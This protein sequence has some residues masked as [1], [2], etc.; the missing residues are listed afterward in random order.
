LSCSGEFGVALPWELLCADDLAVIAETEEEL[1]GRLNV[2]K[3]NVESGGVVVGVGKTRVVV[4]GECR[5]VARRVV[6]WPCGV[7]GEGVGGDS[8]QCTSCQKWVHG[9]C[10]G[11]GGSMLRVARSFVCRGCVG[12]VTSA[13]CTGVD[14]GASAGLKL[15]DRFCYLGGMLGAVGD[16]DAAVGAGV[17]VELTHKVLN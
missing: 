12:P 14:V 5:R 6:E 10:S 8:L 13:G 9:R 4:S 1:I 11:M 16:T 2:W 3:E 15:V 17:R 7:C